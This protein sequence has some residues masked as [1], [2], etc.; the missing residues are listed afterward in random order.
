VPKKK[1]RSFVEAHALIQ[2]LGLKGEKEWREY[3]RLGNKPD[4]IPMTPHATYKNKGWISYGDWLGTGS[5]A[6]FKRKYRTF[7]EARKFARS[8]NLKKGKEWQEYAKSDKKPNDIPY[9]PDKVYK[10]KGW[11]D[12]GDWL[13]TG[14]VAN[15]NRVFLPF[16]AARKF[17]HTLKITGYNDWIA[18]TKS[19]KL[20]KNIPTHPDRTYKKEGWKDWGD[21][22]GTGTV[23]YSKRVIRPFFEAR[24]FARSLNMKSEQ[25]WRKYAKS[26]K[27]PADIPSAPDKQYKND[28]WKNWGDWFGTGTIAAQIIGKNWLPWKEAKPLYQ[29]LAK[30]FGVKN[31]TDWKNFLKNHDMPPRLPRYP[32]EV[33]TEER[34]VRRK[35]KK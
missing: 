5:I 19:K 26:Y 7:E 12:M 6:T 2:K 8:L 28:G 32:E 20:P 30:K 3:C 13:G 25:V 14:F 24:K 11:K 34:V 4:D 29:K 21:W 18:Y 27:K 31:T 15:F 23:A 1:F 9:S 16:L 17:V 22:L 35:T 33:Y 10:N